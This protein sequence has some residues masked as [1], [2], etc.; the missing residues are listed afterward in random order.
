MKKLFLVIGL[1]AGFNSCSQ[2]E[3]ADSLTIADAKI[4]IPNENKVFPVGTAYTRSQVA[5]EGAYNQLKQ[6]LVKNDAISIVAEVD[7]SKN[8]RMVNEKLDYTKIIFFGNPVLGTPLM[9]QNQLAGL[10]LPQKILFYRNS[11]KN[12]IALYNSMDYLSSRH[13]LQCLESLEKIS[14]AL[15]NLV[16]GATKTEINYAAEQT[17]G[18]GEG[19]ITK[20]SSNN[21][22]DTYSRLKNVLNAN[23]NISIIAELDHKKNAE[24]AGLELNPTRII[25]F[26]NPQL[27]TPLMLEE[28][29]IG[30]DLPQKMLVWENDEAEVFISYNDPF[31]IAE[32]HDIED[33]QDVLNTISTALNKISDEA[34]NN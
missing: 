34:I 18:P 21:F 12:D 27:G 11:K 20:T 10:D 7:H 26:G 23:E 14:G 4:E 1:I 28:Q 19:I 32:R 8:A 29:S 15:Q 9:Q 25:I 3:P 13:E 5:A 24:S 33:N 22:E 30:L 2:N 6:N 31:Y 17:V 16:S